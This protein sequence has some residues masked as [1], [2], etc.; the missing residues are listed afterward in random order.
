MK[1]LYK[2]I[3]LRECF[4]VCRQLLVIITH[5]RSVVLSYV[6]RIDPLFKLTI[7]STFFF[8]P[9]IFI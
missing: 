4:E 5:K 9:G 3:L 6:T 2:A 1:Q 8:Q 7:L